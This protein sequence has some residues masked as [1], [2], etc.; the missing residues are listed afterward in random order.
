MPPKPE[1]VHDMRQEIALQSERIDNLRKETQDL[2]RDGITVQS[3]Y[4]MLKDAIADIR[5]ELA[6]SR[7]RLDEHIKQVETWDARRWSVIML[8]VGAV[9]SLASGLI[10]TLARK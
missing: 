3:D 9:L 8:L 6:L 5:R 7:Q 10:V 4:A 2:A 1:Y